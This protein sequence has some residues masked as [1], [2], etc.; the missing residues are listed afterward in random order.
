MKWCS[1][2]KQI[3]MKTSTYFLHISDQCP[4][5][6][7]NHW[8][9]PIKKDV[10]F[11][12]FEKSTEKHLSQSLFFNV[13]DTAWNFI[14]KGTPVLVLTCKFWKIFKNTFFAEHLCTI[15]SESLKILVHKSLKFVDF[16]K[17]YRLNHHKKITRNLSLPLRLEYFCCFSWE[18]IRITF[19]WV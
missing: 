15:A 17:D 1:H 18:S 8:R 10:F 13:T 5:F 9:C 2:S 14:G 11:K 4:M 16:Q 12:N 7:S 6:R 3:Y 19:L